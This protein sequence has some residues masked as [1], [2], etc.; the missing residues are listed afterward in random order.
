MATAGPVVVATDLT[1]ASR[2]ALERG[3]VLAAASGAPLVVCHVV[4]DVF[5][6][7]PLMPN[8]AEN[9]LLLGADLIARA[10][11]LVNDQVRAVL[12]ESVPDLRVT[13]ESGAPDEEI[14]RVAEASGASLIVVGAK[15]RE[16]ARLALGHVAERVVR[17]AHAS[18]LVAR[19]GR[20]TGKL[21]VTTD[22]SEGS[23]PALRVAGDL[24]RATGASATLLH[25]VTPPSSALSSALMPFGDTWTPPAASAVEA[26]EALGQAT[27]ASLTT[28]HGFAGFEQRAGE[29]ADVILQRAEE[30]DVE[31]IVTGSRGRRGLA[32]LVLGSVAEKVIRNSTCSVLVAREPVRDSLR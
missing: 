17:Y 12:G 18:V 3:R 21:L 24:A 30:L 32:R 1:D 29:P 15:P 2:P 22:F 13:V 25:V 8:A 9:D 23:L 10:G 5:R 20:A 31:M 27:L 4:L 6:H 11:D 28:E 16:G 26:L 7:H 14:V 19:E